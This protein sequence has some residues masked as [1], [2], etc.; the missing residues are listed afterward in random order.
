MYCVSSNTV[1]PIYLKS[2]NKSLQNFCFIPTGTLHILSDSSYYQGKQ[3][4]LISKEILVDFF[5]ISSTEI[6]NLQYR[7]FLADLIKNNEIEKYRIAIVDTQKWRDQYGYNEPYVEY[8]FQHPAYN[9]YPCVNMSYEGAKLYCEWFSKKMNQEQSEYVIEA[10]LP[11]ATQWEYATRGGKKLAQFSWGGP[12]TENKIGQKLANY[13]S[14]SDGCIHYNDSSK[15]YEIVCYNPN[16]GIAGNLNDNADV[17][18]P[19]ISYQTNDFGLYNSCGN[20]AE[21]IETKGIARGGSWH[22]PGFDIQVTSEIKYDYPN[23]Y[24]GFRPILIVRRK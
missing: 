4:R 11:N 6:S 7:E 8:Y 24:V 2:K 22:S 17:T 19:V 18:A 16:M 13:K 20:V 10:K 21:M 5:Y 15:Q 14:I 1:K 9:Q 12:Y 3:Q 23:P